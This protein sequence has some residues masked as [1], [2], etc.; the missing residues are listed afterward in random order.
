M[1]PRTAVRFWRGSPIGTAH[2]IAIAGTEGH[3]SY[4]W[5]ANAIELNRHTTCMKVRASNKLYF[6]PSTGGLKNK[7]NDFVPTYAEEYVQ[8]R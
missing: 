6:S 7:K 8:D 1:I 3:A 2:A 5:I 4:R